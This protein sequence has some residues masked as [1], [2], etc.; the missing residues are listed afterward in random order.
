MNSPSDQVIDHLRRLVGF[1]TTSSL[2]NRPLIDDVANVLEDIADEIAI[3]E[4]PEQHGK[5]SLLARVGP[6]KPGG[7]VLSGHSDC[8]PVDGQQWHHDP[9]TMEVVDERAS[10]RGTSDMKGF[11]AVV[12]AAAPALAAAELR[13]PIHV[14]ISHDEELGALSAGTLAEQLLPHR[15]VLA[16][17]GEP[18]RM[19][20]VAGH[21]GVRGFR[22]TITGRAGHSSQPGQGAN[23]AIAAAH[24]VAFIDDLAAEV[25][26]A[27]GD[28]RFDPPFTTFG[29]GRIEGG[30]ALNVIPQRAEVLFEYRP[31]PDDDTDEYEQRIRA[32]VADVLVPGLQANAPEADID[33]FAWPPLPSLRPFEDADAAAVLEAIAPGQPKDGTA[34]FG[35]D[36][37]HFAAAGIPTVI[38]GPG[39]I[40]DAHTANESIA[41]AELAAAEDFIAGVAAWAMT[42]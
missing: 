35:T 23:A 10:G 16:V 34:A 13:R 19:R 30:A 6:E 2:P 29:V 39:D 18:T 1:D 37:G 21:K 26:A 15:P 27:P 31:V 32:H 7:L 22:A 4:D 5:A 12:L 8:V 14:A 36:G 41:L 38:L 25:A 3:L 11:L 20:I 33:V 24:L 28:D 40:A 42:G 9:F 17:V